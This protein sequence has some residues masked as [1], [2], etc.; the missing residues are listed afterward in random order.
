M[1]KM[2][3]ITIES[4]N[5]SANPSEIEEILQKAVLAL[6]SQRESRPLKDKFL[7]EEVEKLDIIFDRVIN[8]MISK[9]N[10]VLV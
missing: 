2:K 4:I 5:C 1:F 9:I 8:N 10:E 3:T 7:Q 6:Q